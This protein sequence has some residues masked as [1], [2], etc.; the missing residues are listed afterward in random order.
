MSSTPFGLYRDGTELRGL[1]Y[2]KPKVA[3]DACNSLGD[4]CDY[5]VLVGELRCVAHMSTC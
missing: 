1:Y 5:G 2:A 4:R 3:R